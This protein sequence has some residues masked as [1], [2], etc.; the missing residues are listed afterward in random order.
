MPAI[1]RKA[2]PCTFYTEAKQTVPVCEFLHW[3]P[4]RFRTP[5]AYERLRLAGRLPFIQKGVVAQLAEATNGI[6]V[7]MEH[8]YYGQSM[9]TK[10]LSTESLRFLTTEQALADTVY[11]VKNVVFEGFEDED[12][13]APNTP[14]ILYGGSYAGGQVVC[15]PPSPFLTR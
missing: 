14:Y 13:T 15:F 7:V 3:S 8:R 1:T 4:Y 2:A 11:F 10:D 6:A 12:L 5:K 9:P